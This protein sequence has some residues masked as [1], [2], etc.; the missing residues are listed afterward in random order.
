MPLIMTEGIED[1]IT[2][3]YIQTYTYMYFT[4][5]DELKSDNCTW[6]CTSSQYNFQ[7]NMFVSWCSACGSQLAGHR[8]TVRT[9]VVLTSKRRESL[10]REHIP[11]TPHRLWTMD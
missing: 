1:G 3:T 6:N 5:V 7:G 9:V 11:Y 4:P 2:Y 8:H 10:P